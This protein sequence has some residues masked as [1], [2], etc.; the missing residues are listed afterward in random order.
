MHVE[1]KAR[2]QDDGAG[3]NSLSRQR[4]AQTDLRV[5]RKQL[6][7]CAISRSRDHDARKRLHSATGGRDAA[8][9]L[10]LLAELGR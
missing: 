5:G 2:R 1:Q 9:S 4:H 3:A 6:R 7:C 10:E 8:D